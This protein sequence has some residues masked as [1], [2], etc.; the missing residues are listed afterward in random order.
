M[1]W[2]ELWTQLFVLSTRTRVRTEDRY[3]MKR[4]VRELKREEGLRREKE[5]TRQK[6]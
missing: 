5:E 4:L 3:R 2:R 1:N 6:N